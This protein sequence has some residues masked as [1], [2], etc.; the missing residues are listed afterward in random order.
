MNERIS[1]EES[2]ENSL[3]YFLEALRILELSAEEQCEA[4]GNYNVAW[5]MQHDISGSISPLVTCSVSYFTE[6]QTSALLALEGAMK[7]LPEEA[8]VPEGMSTKSHEGSIATMQ[9]HAWEPLRARASELLQMLEPAIQR[10]AAYFKQ[11]TE[12]SG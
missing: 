6:A 5:E 12:G 1:V 11:S 10:N 2:F 9:H 4:M 3:F 7:E 8:L